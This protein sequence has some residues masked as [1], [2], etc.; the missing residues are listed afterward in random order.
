LLFCLSALLPSAMFAQTDYFY[1]PDGKKEIMRMKKDMALVRCTPETNKEAWGEQFNFNTYYIYNENYMIV[2]FDSLRLNIENLR[3]NRNV[4]DVVY[5]LEYEDGA[6]QIPTHTIIVKMWVG[7]EIELLLDDM[8][9]KDKVVKME[10]FDRFR[11]IYIIELSIPLRDI[12][13]TCRTLFETGWCEIAE[14]S[15]I[16][17]ITFFGSREP[18]LN[19]YFENQWGLKNTGQFE[20]DFAGIDINAEAAW[21]ITKGNPTIKIAVL[22]GG[23][24]LDHPDLVDNLALELGYDAYKWPNGDSYGGHYG[25]NNDHGTICAGVIGAVDNEIG[26]IGVAPKCKIVPIRIGSIPNSRGNLPDL[27][28]WTEDRYIA[29][30]ITYAYD[31]AHVDILNCSWGGLGTPWNSTVIALERAKTFGRNGKGCVIVAAAGK[32]P[33]QL[34]EWPARLPFVMAVGGIDFFA[35]R[36]ILSPFK[37]NTV[38]VVAP[39]DFIYT[40]TLTTLGHGGYGNPIENIGYHFYTGTSLACPHV[41]GVAALMLSVNPCLEEKEVRRLIALSC[42]KITT[43]KYRYTYFP[44]HEFGAWNNEMGYGLIDAHKAVLY[45]LAQPQIFNESGKEIVKI[46]NAI[47]FQIENDYYFNA[48]YFG[49]WWDWNSNPMENGTYVVERYEVSATLPFENPILSPKVEGIANGFSTEVINNGAYYME[50]ENLTETSVTVKTYVYKVLQTIG[51]SP[52]HTWIPTPPEEVRFHV[53]VAPDISTLNYNLYLQNQ[54]ITSVKNYS[55]ITNIAAGREVT[56]EIPVGNYEV[57]SGANVTI[58]AGESILLDDGFI[59]N[60]G[61]WLNAFIEPFFICEENVIA[62]SKENNEPVYVISDYNVEKTNAP[63]VA[64]NISEN[65]LYLKIYPN[66][67]SGDVTIEYNLNRSE[68]VEI[69]LHDN[70]GKRVYKLQNRAA[71][72]AGVYKI[73]LTGVELP[74]GIYF[75][76]LKTENLQKTEKLLM[77]R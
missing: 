52:V 2:S 65:E 71:H 21:E 18:N 73:M 74:A 51:N 7:R 68:V 43:E 31:T 24:Q 57:A 8:G 19:P 36:E 77:V 38:D 30:G 35:S 62:G 46:S 28:S 20:E 15:F 55:V 66:P 17:Q 60:S 42:R 63:D 10:F 33:N 61:S 32:D 13:Q 34:V 76:T 39:G 56:Q 69:T 37:G 70:F 40:T 25:N 16:R 44:T 23:V 14:P 22:D 26:I 72:D 45:A 29:K 3:Q 54:T 53:S 9:I 4:A 50:H 6:I 27:K 11:D 58:R 12:L 5:A 49:D 41:A 1:S 75:C 47:N 48:Y 64:Q 59:A 67:S